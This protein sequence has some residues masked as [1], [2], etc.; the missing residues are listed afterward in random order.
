[1]FLP[2]GTHGKICDKCNKR[3]NHTWTTTKGISYNKINK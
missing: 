3:V 1:M 2:T